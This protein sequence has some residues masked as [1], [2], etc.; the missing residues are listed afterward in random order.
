VA[1]LRTPSENALRIARRDGEC[2][3]AARTGGERMS[4][5]DLGFDESRL[6]RLSDLVLSA[7]VD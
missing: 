6:E 7:V 4:A 1:A 2:G 5:R 3:I